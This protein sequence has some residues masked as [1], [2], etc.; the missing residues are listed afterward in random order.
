MPERT[1][2]SRIGPHSVPSHE[3]PRNAP[4]AVSPDPEPAK[5]DNRGVFPTVGAKTK[6]AVVG[7][8]RQ[9]KRLGGKIRRGIPGLKPKK[10]DRR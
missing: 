2:E 7:T 4:P 8:G 10:N 3:A 5:K 6:E 1:P 9:F